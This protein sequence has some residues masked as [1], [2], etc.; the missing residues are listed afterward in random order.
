MENK[1]KK[2][3]TISKEVWA[4]LSKLKIDLGLNTLDA[5]LSYLL[6]GGKRR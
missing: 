4:E 1:E 5:L 2:T 6:K 3:I